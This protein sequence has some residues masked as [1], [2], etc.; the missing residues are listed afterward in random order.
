MSIKDETHKKN[1]LMVILIS[2]SVVLGIIDNLITAKGATALLVIALV[3]GGFSGILAYLVI[4]KKAV[5]Y[6]VYV[7]IVGLQLLVLGLLILAP[8]IYSYLVIYLTLFLI[9][10][11]QNYK[12]VLLSGILSILISTYA[13]LNYNEFI[14]PNYNSMQNIFTFNFLIGLAVFLIVLQCRYSQ[15]LREVVDKN[16]ETLLKSRERNEKI[17]Q[18]IRNSV[19]ILAPFSES[20]KENMNLTRAISSQ[21]TKTFD[22]IGVS[23]EDEAASIGEINQFMQFNKNQLGDVLYSSNTMKGLSENTLAISKSGNQ[24]MSLLNEKINDVDMQIDHSVA[25]MNTLTDRVKKIEEILTT[26]NNIA[27]QTNLL[28][29]NA[30]I[31]SARAGEAGRGFAV[32]ADEIRKLAEHSQ[33]SNKLISVILQEIQGETNNVANKIINCQQSVKNS[34]TETNGVREIIQQIEVNTKDVVAQSS[35]LDQKISSLTDSFATIGNKIENIYSIT[36]SNLS[37][38]QEAVTSSHQQTQNVDH[39]SNGYDKVN[40]LITELTSVSKT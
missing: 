1:Q 21:L 14:F 32:V 8:G 23:V 28:A 29:L 13:L 3:G 6:V 25:L 34:K 33:E 24:K 39:L 17:L 2:I 35:G 10:L 36:Q 40:Q 26:V 31:E 19:E 16:Q 4:R 37:S 9:S 18:Q 12:P 22:T 38:V 5:D 15:R 11:Y 27:E 20:L 30:S 7:A